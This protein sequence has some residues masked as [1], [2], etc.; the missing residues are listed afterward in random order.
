[1]LIQQGPHVSRHCSTF[2]QVCKLNR[3]SFNKDPTCRGTA[4]PSISFASSIDANS[5]RTPR[6]EALQHLQSALQA[7]SMLI[8]Q[9]HHVLR[10]CCT[11]NQLRKLTRSY[12]NKDPTCR[13]T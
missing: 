3:C 12:F 13:G 5:T 6:V 4:A 1:M 11:F 7:Q 9:G 2:N 10:H 8:Q